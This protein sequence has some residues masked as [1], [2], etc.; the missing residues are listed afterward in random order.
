MMMYTT[1]RLKLTT[2]TKSPVERNPATSIRAPVHSALHQHRISDGTGR[3][4]QKIAPTALPPRIQTATADTA[5]TQDAGGPAEARMAGFP[6][7]SQSA[8]DLEAELDVPIALPG[9]FL[10]LGTFR[11][12]AACAPA[13]NRSCIQGLRISRDPPGAQPPAPANTTH[14]IADDRS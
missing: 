12:S 10:K 8:V 5:C 7:R 11:F 13:S 2:Q 14:A 3:G 6:T 1:I 4:A 9:Q